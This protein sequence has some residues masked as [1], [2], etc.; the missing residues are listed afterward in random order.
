[1]SNVA[2]I[3]RKQSEAVHVVGRVV[4]R[5]N[6]GGWLLDLDGRPRRALQAVGCIVEPQV[7]DGVLALVHEKGILD[8]LGVSIGEVLGPKRLAVDGDWG[9]GPRGKRHR[10]GSRRLRA[11]RRPACPH[12]GGYRR[13]HRGRGERLG[14]QGH[15]RRRLPAGRGLGKVIL[16]ASSMSSEVE[17]V[18]QRMKRSLRVVEE[19]EHVR[20]GTIDYRAEDMVNVRGKTTLVTAETLVKLD[21]EQVHLG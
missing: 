2:R 15:A 6:Q 18:V 13:R 7:G 12:H 14:R 10:R 20:A 17:R 19:G 3:Q 11:G 1:M 4:G 21:G 8:A 9:R 16:F 5:D